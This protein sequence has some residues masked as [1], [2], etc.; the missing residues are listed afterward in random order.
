M[1]IVFLISTLFFTTNLFA[2]TLTDLG[3]KFVTS[4]VSGD[5]VL[6]EKTLLP[7]SEQ[8][9]AMLAAMKGAAGA[10][11]SGELTIMHV[12]RE[13]IIGNLG[14]TLIK[15][16]NK[17]GDVD[18]DPILYVQEGGSWYIIPWADEKGLRVFAASRSEDEQIHLK[19][20]NEWA[21]LLEKQ[22]ESKAEQGG[23]P[24]PLPAE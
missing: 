20:F 9:D 7:N 13:L 2:G 19:L 11:E 24:N 21:H 5:F 23:A 10:V 8:K 4:A 16:Q 22:L 1:K 14:A 3:S 15:I 12:D 17:S 6:V 18:Y